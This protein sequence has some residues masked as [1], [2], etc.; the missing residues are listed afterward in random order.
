MGITKLVTETVHLY[1]Q[2]NSYKGE[3]MV[4]NDSPKFVAIFVGFGGLRYQVLRFRRKNGTLIVKNTPHRGLYI[5][6]DKFSPEEYKS[7]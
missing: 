2:D 4:L 1:D 3:Y 6:N 5:R 7:V